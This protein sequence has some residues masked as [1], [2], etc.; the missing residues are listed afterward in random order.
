MANDLEY[1]VLPAEPLA[2]PSFTAEVSPWGVGCLLMVVA[3]FISAT[4]TTVI[5]DTHAAMSMIFLFQ[6]GAVVLAFFIYI[7]RR[8]TDIDTQKAKWMSRHIAER[9]GEARKLAQ[10]AG[11]AMDR[12]YSALRNLPGCLKEVDIFLSHAE[13]EFQER[14]YAPFWDN[15]EQAA[16]KLGAFNYNLTR[17][18]AEVVSYKNLLTGQV[19]NFPPLLIQR[20]N[21]LRRLVRM[22]QKD[23]EFATIWEHR[24]TQ[25]VI[26]EGFRTLGEAVN[27]LGLTI[28]GSFSRVTKTIEECSN[29][30]MEEQV[31]LRGSFETAVRKWE[32]QKR[33][34]GG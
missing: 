28:D 5:K 17:M 27:N 20:D 29:R 24:K 10:R 1:S 21:R 13:E 16:L 32:E 33:L 25:N 2:P 31:R 34:Y 23:F 12:F 3:L 19:H 15:I 22:G 30:Q 8:K 18:E 6:I 7:A 9:E 11:Q 26:L 14:A 4:F